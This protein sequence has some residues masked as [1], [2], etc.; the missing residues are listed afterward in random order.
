MAPLVV[1][2]V[3]VEVDPELVAEPEEA[4]PDESVT[5]TVGRDDEVPSG[6]VPDSDVAAGE[7]T[8]GEDAEELVVEVTT[9]LLA[10]ED[11]VDAVVDAAEDGEDETAEDEEPP[12]IVNFG[13]MF[14]ESP[15]TV[16]CEKKIN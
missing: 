15:R 13:E 1:P 14:P 9:T 2:A 4:E 16:E 5:E 11:A 8:V 6:P 7:V 12:V 3:V 10:S